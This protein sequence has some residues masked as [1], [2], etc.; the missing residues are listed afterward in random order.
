[1]PDGRW[2]D[3]SDRRCSRVDGPAH[4]RSTE[5]ANENCCHLPHSPRPQRRDQRPAPRR[6]TRI[7]S[8]CRAGASPAGI[9][10]GNRS[11]C[12]TIFHPPHST[13]EI[14]RSPF[15]I[16]SLPLIIVQRF[17]AG[18]TTS[19]IDRVPQYGRKNL[20][21]LTGL[22]NPG[23]PCRP[24]YCRAGASLA[25]R[26]LGRRLAPAANRTATGA[27]ALQFSILIPRSQVELGNAIGGFEVELRRDRSVPKCNLGTREQMET[28]CPQAVEVRRPF[29]L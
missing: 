1:M 21:S 2:N 11:G 26:S 14:P 7:A 20:P 29:I 5:R 6:I 12:P 3:R 17:S 18:T 8:S 19:P 22:T 15:R 13:F 25:R 27:V 24:I 16:S 4:R 9:A 10:D 23:I 28:A